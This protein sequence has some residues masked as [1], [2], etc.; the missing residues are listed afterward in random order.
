VTKI[1]QLTNRVQGTTYR[2]V[3][4][5]VTCGVIVTGTL[6]VTWQT[7]VITRIVVVHVT[8]FHTPVSLAL[9]KTGDTLAVTPTPT[10]S[11][12]TLP[13][14]HLLYLTYT[15]TNDLQYTATIRC[16]LIKQISHWLAPQVPQILIGQFYTPNPLL[17]FYL[18]HSE[19]GRFSVTMNFCLSALAPVLVSSEDQLMVSAK[20][21]CL[22]P[23]TITL[24]NLMDSSDV[25]PSC[26]IA[27][28]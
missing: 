17:K 18:R 8:C 12:C 10:P 19:I 4:D 9:V 21:S 5:V 13:V 1:D 23:A 20:H 11:R 3:T 28:S 14:T 26:S 6:G 7:C 24:P 15:N 2:S 16:C 25:S 27:V 22:F